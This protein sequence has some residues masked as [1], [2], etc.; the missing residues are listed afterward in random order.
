MNRPNSYFGCGKINANL[1]KI[2]C[3]FRVFVQYEQREG[4]RPDLGTL[5]PCCHFI[6]FQ[7]SLIAKG[8]LFAVIF[9][10]TVKHEMSPIAPEIEKTVW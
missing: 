2:A 9:A 7:L 8:C 5:L 4:F 6:R 1:F 10:A 3:R